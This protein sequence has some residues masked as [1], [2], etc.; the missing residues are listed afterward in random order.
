M[1]EWYIYA[2]NCSMQDSVTDVGSLNDWFPV[3]K[4]PMTWEE[5]VR[6]VTLMDTTH[7]EYLLVPNHHVQ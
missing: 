1:K 6:K 4:T 7:Q 2:R 5:A 3:V